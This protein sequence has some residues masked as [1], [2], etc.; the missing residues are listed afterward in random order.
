M[1]IQK[2]LAAVDSSPRAASVV[3]AAV[4][5]AARYQAQVVLL[6]VLAVPQEYPAAAANLDDPLGKA[7][8]QEAATEL[9][10]LARGH[11]NLTVAAPVVFAGQPWRAILDAAQS[12]G[13]D[14]IVVGSHGYSGWDRILGTTASKVA[15]H[16]DRSVLVV[17]EKR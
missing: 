14:L 7:L 5:L 15:D 2:I 3:A 10:V 17:H 6:R 16:A 13:A 1:M 4:D 11:A 12:L 9:E 8:V